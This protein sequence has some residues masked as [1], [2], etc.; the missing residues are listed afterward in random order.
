MKLIKKKIDYLLIF[1][2]L[3]VLSLYAFVGDINYFF[4]P[5]HSTTYK[6][7][8]NAKDVMLFSPQGQPLKQAKIKTYNP[9]FRLKVSTDG[10]KTYLNL[11]VDNFNKIRFK[12]ISKYVISYR[13]KFPFGNL[14]TV[15]SFLVKAKHKSKEIYTKP[16][17]ITYVQNY[18]SNFPFVSLIINEDDLFDEYNGMMVLGK[19]SWIED[20]L[21]FYKNFWFKDANYKQRKGKWRKKTYFQYFEKGKLK[22]ELICEASISGNATRSFAQKSIKLKSVKQLYAT[23][24]FKYHFFGKQG[25]SKYKSLVLRNSGNDNT[26]TLFADRLMQELAIKDDVLYQK[27]QFVNVFINGNYWGIYNLRERYDSYFISKTE[28]VEKKDITLLEGAYAKLKTGKKKIQKQ[29]VNYIDSLYQLDEITN[30]I[31]AEVES[32][33]NLNSFINYTF[34]QTFFANGDWLI[35]NIL[36]YKAGTKKWKWALNDLDYGL[37]YQGEH[38]VNEN[39]FDKLKI[40]QSY[41]GKLYQILLKNKQFKKR[42]KNQLYK[43]INRMYANNRVLNIYQS[44]KTDLKINIQWQ[45]NRWRVI[46]S[47]EEWDENCKK[48]LNFLLNRREVYK[49]QIDSI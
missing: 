30:A 17:Q 33:I 44:L 18:K 40:N 16:I 4:K 42:F 48:N 28:N 35:N 1:L 46:K 36:V 32:K 20:D 7:Y 22:S 45:I 14:P 31:L 37:A 3:S 34:N 12:D 19:E 29:Y 41:F 43:N 9:N 24:K 38:N 25:L 26:K 8:E 2:L 49:H 23:D 11:S 39:I 27:G 47:I 5:A 15:K 13:F 10:G 6:V 21:P